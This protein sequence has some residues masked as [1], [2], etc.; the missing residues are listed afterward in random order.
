MF[1]RPAIIFFLFL[2]AVVGLY[3]HR[4]VTILENPILTAFS[5]HQKYLAVANKTKF[6]IFEGL[7]GKKVMDMNLP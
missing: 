3:P 7:S 4:H 5:A 2:S 1:I 6:Q